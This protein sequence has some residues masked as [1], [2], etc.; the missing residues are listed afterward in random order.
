MR[1]DVLRKCLSL[2]GILLLTSSMVACSEEEVRVAVVTRCPP[3]KKYSLEFQKQV[4]SEVRAMIQGSGAAVM[5]ADYGTLR[6]RCRA[7]AAKAPK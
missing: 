6:A 2:I 7:Y 5:I 3:L 4:A 1:N